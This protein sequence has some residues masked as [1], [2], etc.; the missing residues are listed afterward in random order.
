MGWKATNSGLD[1]APASG[2]GDG[3]WLLRSSSLYVFDV[4][5]FRPRWRIAPKW[6]EA[7]KRARSPLSSCPRTNFLSGQLS[8]TMSN[9]TL[10]KGTLGLKFMNRVTPKPLISVEP[11]PPAAVAAPPPTTPVA[12][13]RP[14][15]AKQS[16]ATKV[17]K[18]VS[19]EGVEE[20]ARAGP[21]NP[22]P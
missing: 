13:A 11:T 10:S 20:G 15:P 1:A 21:S 16:G 4:L 6:S 2:E 22:A 9:R 17:E 3:D 14:P 8:R 12:A 5:P 19:M 7:K 18:E